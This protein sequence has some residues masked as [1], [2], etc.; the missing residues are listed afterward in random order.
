M[1]KREHRAT[2]LDV[3][4]GRGRFYA[5]WSGSGKRLGVTVWNP[6]TSDQRQVELRPDQVQ[7]LFDFPAETLACEPHDR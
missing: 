6:I 4:G 1:S 5:I 3:A 7:A 2:T